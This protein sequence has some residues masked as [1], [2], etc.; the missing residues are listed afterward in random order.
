MH[1]RSQAKGVYAAS[2]D[3]AGPY[4][5]GQG[6]DTTASGRDRHHGYRYF[7]ACA[8]TIPMPPYGVLP[9]ES[10][11]TAVPSGSP[12]PA[13][14]QEDLFKEVFG[15]DFENED[16]LA[17][18]LE[19]LG[20][21]ASV[22]GLAVGVGKVTRRVSKKG[23]ESP[24]E[25]P[26]PPPLPPPS[27]DPSVRTRMLTLGV[28][29][30]SKKIREVLPAIQ[31][32][33][34]RLT[35]AGFPVNR[36]HSDRA[37]EFRARPLVTWLR[38][39]GIHATWAPAESPQGNRAE[40]AVQLIKGLS[41]KLLFAAKLP[42]SYWPL[43]VLHASQR[44][45][46]TLFT[47]LGVPQPALL[48]FGMQLQARCR[49][50]VKE[51]EWAARAHPGQYMGQAPD[52]PGGHLVLI[53]DD[54]GGSK[55]LLTSTVFPLGAREDVPPK[56]RYRLKG[57]SKPE[58]ALRPVSIVAMSP[59]LSEPLANL[60]RLSPGGEW[61]NDS[62][63]DSGVS[64]VSLQ[65]A[66][67]I[68]CKN[69]LEPGMAAETPPSGLE[70]S[71]FKGEQRLV[72][73]GIGE[74]FDPDDEDWSFLNA[75]LE[76]GRYDFKSCLEV[77]RTWVKSFPTPIRKGL[78]GDQAYAVLGLYCQGGL[79]GVARFAKKIDLLTR[80]LN[81]F[82]GRH[83]PIGS[84]ATLYLSRNT[85]MSV[86]R[87][88]RNV[89]GQPTWIVALGDFQGGGLW[90]CNGDGNGPVLKRLPDGR[91]ASGRVLDI[92][93]NPQT[94][95]SSQW[96]E[97]QAWVGKDRWVLVAYVPKGYERVS[98]DCRT[99]LGMLGFPLDVFQGVGKGEPGIQENAGISSVKF[100]PESVSP[101]DDGK[102]KDTWEVDFPCEVWDENNHDHRVEM[103][104]EAVDLC[105]RTLRD[106][107]D[108]QSPVLSAKLAEQ[109]SIARA[110]C[111]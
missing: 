16:A 108:S 69:W 4:P 18:M 97:T 53:S 3:L 67:N 96:H 48:P 33:I 76:T 101:A 60:A 36:Y 94:F 65:E 89:Q 35:A 43:A 58:F 82:V 86:H 50:R 95:D 21:E 9:P 98:E 13:T 19:P 68:E 78:E 8:F 73:K 100:N 22:S 32:V 75:Y 20:E 37:G 47:E 39:Q 57:K 103:H 61:E 27:K 26:E 14:E 2:F 29:L 77:L 34:N 30:R 42:T 49:F 104:Q 111:V 63:S 62:D 79:R 109:V 52:T 80:Y 106:L 41:R 28:P 1:R 99:E 56:P 85:D 90:V 88:A 81:G 11:P 40:L 15:S 17:D 110:N 59:V 105:L 84:W 6:Y 7:L 45:W 102:F 10:A 71:E 25:P 51:G 55:V 54:T 91:V 44:A 23:P 38:A 46:V 5:P 74:S 93:N 64:V 31:G 107:Q 83:Y 12:A 87:D 92:H 24:S 72:S 70:G 66:P